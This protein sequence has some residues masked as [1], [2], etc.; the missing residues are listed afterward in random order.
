MA[1]RLDKELVSR[2]LA[3]TRSRAQQLIDSGAVLVNG[4]PE[5]AKASLTVSESDEI[6]VNA[7]IRSSG[8]YV[9]RGAIKLVEALEIF[10]PHGLPTPE[11]KNCLDVG[12]STG[13]FTQVLL[14]QGAQ[15]VIALDVGH[16]QLDPLIEQDLRVIDASGVNIR[17][18]NP[19]DL[20]F[21]PDLVVSDVSFISL[22]YVIPVLAQ[23]MPT[24]SHAVLLIKPQFEVGRS[25]LGKGGIVTQDAYR[26]EAIDKVTQCAQDQ[27]FTIREVTPSAI[28]GT[29]GNQEYLLW[30]TRA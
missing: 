16:D 21:A 18:V 15:K 5:K 19:A 29:H 1:Q 3:P 28:T 14:Q 23:I 27:G 7:D 4:S 26:Q 6:R 8:Q 30:I 12:A 2:G 13:G 10:I 11:G 20:E 9:S 22:T 17:D 25:K 24:D